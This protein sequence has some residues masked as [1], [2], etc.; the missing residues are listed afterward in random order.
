MPH[1]GA[2]AETAQGCGAGGGAGGTAGTAAV[3]T[4]CCPPPARRWARKNCLCATPA[5]R[6]MTTTW[7][8]SRWVP[9]VL[10]LPLAFKAVGAPPGEVLGSEKLHSRLRQVALGWEGFR[11]AGPWGIRPRSSPSPP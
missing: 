6:S 1:A 5:P 4:F 8:P 7:A 9:H 11:K 10:R 3:S 2:V